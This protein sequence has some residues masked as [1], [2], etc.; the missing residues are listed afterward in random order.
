MVTIASVSRHPP[1]TPQHSDDGEEAEGV[2]QAAIDPYPRRT[3]RS[4]QNPPRVILTGI[5][6]RSTQGQGVILSSG[7]NESLPNIAKSS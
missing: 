7:S 4:Y 6:R 1:T 2:A 5:D 3:E